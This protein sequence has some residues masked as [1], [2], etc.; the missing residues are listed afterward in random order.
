M[1]Q[2]SFRFDGW[3]TGTKLLVLLSLALFPLGL[4]LA[5]TAENSLDDA[6]AAIIEVSNDNARMAAQA[7]ESLIARNAL[8]LRVAAN[9]AI[10]ANPATACQVAAQS[11]ALTPSVAN[12]FSLRRSD[13]STLCDTGDYVASGS[14]RIVA[15]GALEIWLATDTK[16]LRYRVGV[17]EG[18][19]TGELTA[20][21]IE[22][23]VRE[24]NPRIGAFSLGD[25]RATLVVVSEDNIAGPSRT[26]QYRIAGGQMTAT[27]RVPIASAS[28]GDRLALLLPLLMW[29]IAALLSWYLARRLLLLPLA[30]L[31][32]AVTNYQPGEGA[33]VLPEHLGGAAEIRSLGGAFERAVD[34]LESSEQQMAEALNGQR[35]LVR[36]VHHRV[37]NNL[38]VIASLLNIHGRSATTPESRAAYAAIGRRVDALSV[39][40]RNHFAEVEESRGIALRPLL[41]ELGQT[42]R[43]SAPEGGVGAPNHL[44]ADALHTTQDAAVAVSF[45][46]TELIEY[47]ML[48]GTSQ[49]IEIELRRI[50][51]L[52]ASLTVSSDA[53]I[54]DGEE[55]STERQQFERVIGGLA[56]QLRSPLD[57]KL[58]RLSVNLPVFPD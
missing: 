56:R 30:K 24:S 14:D 54:T 17:N 48:R 4:A 11:L 13:G 44:N 47:A 31:E 20:T 33:L 7:V 32:R 6:E 45:F 28:I 27:V 46:V 53:L 9:G 35:R 15:P 39:V 8:A 58:G 42:L 21:D 51:E 10:K 16:A 55:P 52:A 18:M 5:W 40:H 43:A 1:A 29:V 50:S 12:R 22:R 25:G 34:R 36:E 19:A 26:S 57:Q 49:P 2:R 23:A 3:S 41:T 38:Q 37:K